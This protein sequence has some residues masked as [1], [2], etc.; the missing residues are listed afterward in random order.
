MVI[1]KVGSEGKNRHLHYSLLLTH[2]TNLNRP[3]NHNQHSLDI[4]LSSLGVRG[5]ELETGRKLEG[6]KFGQV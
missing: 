2:T 4:V 3:V 5:T 6:L 1:Y